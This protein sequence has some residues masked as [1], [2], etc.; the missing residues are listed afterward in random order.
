[1]N[2]KF[3]FPS[4][5]VIE[6]TNICNLKCI[7]CEAKC[8]AKNKVKKE[9]LTPE[10]LEIMLEKL[11]DYIVNIAFQGDCEP[12]L[13]S[14]LPQLIKIASK[15]TNHISS[16]SN[17][18]RLS[19]ELVDS[20]IENGL[21]LF[22]ISIDD[23]RPEKY[24]DIRVGADFDKVMENLDY[25][26]KKKEDSKNK[27]QI[28]VHK[29]IFPDN[30]LEDA[31]EFI[32]FFT[33]KH[34]V[35]KVTIAPWVDYGSVQCKISDWI[36]FRNQLENELIDENIY[37]N[38]RDYENY[39][40]RTAHKYYCGTNLFFIDY[41]GNLKSCPIHSGSEKSFGNLL[42]SSLDDIAE[43]ECF[44]EY[45]K[46]WLEKRYGEKLPYMCDNCYILNGEYYCYAL[47]DSVNAINIFR[48]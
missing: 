38:L 25:I 28:I 33:N 44:K 21:S 35:D 20:L 19:N 23:H 6:P 14:Q 48:G 32:K 36:K 42:A 40:Y 39:P 34:P 43:G 41:E 15:Y 37:M 30:T 3:L 1:M 9:E 13:H 16:V 29:I 2:S 4:T 7:M 10:N 22:S 45:H 31:K 27:I 8:S 46:F 47:D 17:G 24:N 12:T 11:K 26:I 18:T 5:V